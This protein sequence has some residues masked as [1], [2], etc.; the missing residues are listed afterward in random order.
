MAERAVKSQEIHVAK[1]EPWA[2][3]QAGTE[4]NLAS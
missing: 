3:E 1:G 4:Q 2:K